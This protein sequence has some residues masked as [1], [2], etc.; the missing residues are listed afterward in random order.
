[1]K[2]FNYIR[3]VLIVLVIVAA[4][5]FYCRSSV[6]DDRKKDT[7]I[8][9]ETD[10][11][12]NDTVKEE[13]TEANNESESS[14]GPKEIVVQICGCVVNPGV[15]RVHAGTRVYEVVDMAGGTTADADVTAV[16][17]AQSI[18]DGQQIYI[19]AAGEDYGESA[20]GNVTEASDDAKGRVNINTADTDMLM[21]L[22]GIGQ[23]KADAIIKYRDDNGRYN[24]IEDIMNVSGIKQAAFDKIKDL[25]CV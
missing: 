7:F 5:I 25:I 22:P 21:S 23:S 6:T 24:T 17:Q 20:D 8:S 11:N 3:Y 12:G 9:S 1:M 18:S 16:N 4:G 19:P 10:G 13:S 15:F 14:T 2:Y